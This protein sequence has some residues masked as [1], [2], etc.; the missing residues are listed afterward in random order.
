MKKLNIGFL[1]LSLVLLIFSTSSLAASGPKPIDSLKSYDIVKTSPSDTFI[2]DVRTRAEYQFV[3][4][5][6]LPSG[7]PNIPLKFYPSW[8]INKNFV[9][10]VKARYKK[11]DTIITL[12]RSGVRAEVAAKLLLD[13]GFI[14]VFYMT[15]S[16]EGAKTD[17]DGHRTVEGWK[18][19]GLPYTYELKG[20]LVYK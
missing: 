6:D 4:H 10:D 13:A 11:D 9:K 8:E 3:G 12:C 5:P 17:V 7:V 18:V 15:D 1:A 14:K 2:I 20:D 16:F 19:N